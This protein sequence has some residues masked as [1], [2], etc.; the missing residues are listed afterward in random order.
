MAPCRREAAGGSGGRRHKLRKKVP[1]K[2]L[3]DKSF[4]SPGPRLGR[5][6]GTFQHSEFHLFL[7]GA[8][9]VWEGVLRLTQTYRLNLTCRRIGEG[10]F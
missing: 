9:S 8:Q 10:A 1:I 4:F 5:K 2:P 7:P 6:P 3:R